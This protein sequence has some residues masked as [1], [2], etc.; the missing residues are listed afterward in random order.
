MCRNLS[1]LRKAK[2]KNTQKDNLYQKSSIPACV[3]SLQQ[4][5]ITENAINWN[6]LSSFSLILK[7]MELDF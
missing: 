6:M 3:I 1:L 2:E 7:R 4:G 5:D